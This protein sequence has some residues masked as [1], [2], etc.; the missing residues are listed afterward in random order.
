[1]WFYYSTEAAFRW[2][3]LKILYWCLVFHSEL[4]YGLALLKRILQTINTRDGQTI[5]TDAVQWL[6]SMDLGYRQ[7]TGI[8]SPLALQLLP[9]LYL[10]SKML[11]YFY[12]GLRQPC[13][14]NWWLLQNTTATFE[15][16]KST[17]ILRSVQQSSFLSRRAQMGPET[18]W[19]YTQITVHK[20]S[21]RNAKCTK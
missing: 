18:P 5:L 8:S 11:H 20:V 1:M 3:K 19:Q 21:T 6:Q 9:Q 14:T 10:V 2:W 12:F 17:T 13:P 4:S 7:A 16:L 15:T